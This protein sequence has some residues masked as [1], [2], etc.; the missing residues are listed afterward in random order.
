MHNSTSS[1]T[2][3]ER[4]VGRGHTQ[5]FKK[6][7]ENAGHNKTR[8][9]SVGKEVQLVYFPSFLC[10]HFISSCPSRASLINFISGICKSLPFSDTTRHLAILLLDHFMEK[11][12]IMDFRL[13][14]VVLTCLLVAAKMEDRDDHLPSIGKLKTLAKLDDFSKDNFQRMELYLMK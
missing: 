7:R 5:D 1:R 9:A 13:K 12:S 3:V 4:P 2:L 11:H 6:E 14:L 8:V 10:F